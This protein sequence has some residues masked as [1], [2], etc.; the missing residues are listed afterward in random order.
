MNRMGRINPAQDFLDPIAAYFSEILGADPLALVNHTFFLPTRRAARAFL[1]KL[2]LHAP[3][4]AVVM[5]RV[6]A[7]SERPLVD[8]ESLPLSLISNTERRLL[9]Y[10]LLMRDAYK[11]KALLCTS[12][13]QFFQF[14]D[15]VLL[16]LD[17]LI[18]YE[19]S[20]ERFARLL[21]LELAAHQTEA[22]KLLQQIYA[23]WFSYLKEQ[24][25]QDPTEARVLSYRAYTRQL[26]DHPYPV[27][28]IGIQAQYGFVV[29]FLKTLHTF[30]RGQ[31]YYVGTR[32]S[33][34]PED[35]DVDRGHPQGHLLQLFKKM[36]MTFED[37]PYLGSDHITSF[38]NFLGRLFDN[39][40]VNQTHFVDTS[41]QHLH[42]IETQNL[43]EEAEVIALLIAESALMPDK[44]VALI[45]SNQSLASIVTALLK[46]WSIVPDQSM[47]DSFKNSSLG[48]LL[49]LSAEF[50][51]GSFSP[52]LFLSLLKHPYVSLGVGRA[53]VLSCVRLLEN[54]VMRTLRIIHDESDLLLKTLPDS[55]RACLSSLIAQ[56]QETQRR[57]KENPSISFA[58]LIKELKAFLAYLV[59]G[60]DLNGYGS[61]FKTPEGQSFE[62]WL[63]DIEQSAV[64]K[65]RLNY[66]YWPEILRV[67]L[68]DLP[69]ATA[70][71]KHPRVFI[72]GPLEA[73]LLSFDRVILPDFNEGRWPRSSSP[74]VWL[75]DRMKE[76]LGMDGDRV[77]MSQQADDFLTFMLQKEVFITRAKRVDGSPTIPS[78]W[79][80]RLQAQL[81]REN[82][83]LPRRDHYQQ[84]A[85][86]LWHQGEKVQSP[87]T[88]PAANPPLSARPRR[89]SLSAIK[90]LK[91]NPYGFYLSDVLRLRPLNP[92]MH[93]LDAPRFGALLH[94]VLAD[95]LLSRDSAAAPSQFFLEHVTSR[96]FFAYIEHPLWRFYWK[97]RVEE[98]LGFYRTLDAQQLQRADQSI[99]EIKVATTLTFP[100]GSFELIAKADRID[101]MGDRTTRI[102]DYKTGKCPTPLEIS[103]CDDVQLALEGLMIQ[104]GALNTYDVVEVSALQ[105]W[106]LKTGKCVNIPD[107]ASC[108]KSATDDL[109]ALLSHYYE[110]GTAYDL[111]LKNLYEDVRHFSRWD[112]WAQ[113]QMDLQGRLGASS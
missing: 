84:W 81:V 109:E 20:P 31:V 103:R 25:Y 32:C 33:S 59:D 47:S 23:V 14:V 37:V 18:L 38:E 95:D 45:T 86:Q 60:T 56:K 3:H 51:V 54:D 67:F 106:D 77:S 68:A 41:I 78:R 102:I 27:I 108:I 63:L 94:A 58:D 28:S 73:R 83:T 111:V 101:V 22:L 88:R 9:M 1:S 92:L 85:K 8:L 17:E 4:D 35:A 105:Y 50:L 15:A 75:G 55:V 49:L 52:T 104:Q 29:D 24:G 107:V 70:W 12:E 16:I 11:E 64:H 5:P 43:F 10:S 2:A 46:R 61:I 80:M 13:R 93:Q 98:A 82:K 110:A 42:C 99:A 62:A 26:Q 71:G 48:R 53:T 44:T 100:F 91:D 79:L 39:Q 7:L 34:M 69:T 89:L 76:S 21:P 87:I 30:P 113:H 65:T 74:S 96:V 6:V 57:I 90:R 97:N 72:L 36:G 19:V 112:E 66:T 40:T